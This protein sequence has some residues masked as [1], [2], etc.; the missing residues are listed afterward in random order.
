MLN[1]HN[2]NGHHRDRRRLLG[3][4][5]LTGGALV[6]LFWVLYLSRAVDL[7]QDDPLV[8]NFESAFPLADAV[9]AAALFAAAYH[10][11]KGQRPGPFFLV[12]AGAMSLYLGILDTTFYV[13]HGILSKI[14]LDDSIGLSIDALCIGGGI[15]ALRFGWRC[16][17]AHAV[18]SMPG[19]VSHR[20]VVRRR[21]I[22]A[23]SWQADHH[24]TEPEKD[25]RLLEVVA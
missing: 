22:G 2:L 1:E 3:W 23:G 5:T 15:V 4:T 24:V 7:G 10:L 25:E 6:L 13:G 8:R 18:S 16:W 12:I 11:L 9:F 21:E 19:T 20:R 14:G 17:M